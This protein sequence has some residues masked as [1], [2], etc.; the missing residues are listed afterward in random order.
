MNLMQYHRT[1]DNRLRLV[2]VLASLLAVA[3]TA[4]AQTN[5]APAGANFSSFQIIVDRNIFNPNRYAHTRGHTRSA[6]PSAPWF[7][8]VGTL[9][10]R[11]GMLAF[12]DGND[13]DYRKVVSPDGIIAGYKVTEITLQGVKLTSTNKT[14]VLKVGAQ[15]RQEG[16]G[17]WQL[18]DSS[19]LPV[20]TAGSETSATEGTSAGDSASSSANEPND[21]LRKLM[22][23]R[24]QELK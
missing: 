1:I 9:G 17:E 14:V 10:S 13:S 4:A 3:W 11:Q 24:E 2:A 21:I 18:A 19:E 8:L 7:S 22:Q 12:F 15:M 6:S 5:N 20:A 16:K 23:Q